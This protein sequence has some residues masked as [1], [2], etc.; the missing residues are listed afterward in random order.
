MYTAGR[1]QRL[2]DAQFSVWAS[3]KR[4]HHTLM[5]MKRAIN[6]M[7]VVV[8]VVVVVLVDK[9]RREFIRGGRTSRNSNAGFWGGCQ[10]PECYVKTMSP[11][12]GQRTSHSHAFQEWHDAEPF[13]TISQYR[14]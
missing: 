1:R 2:A 9:A 12:N 4:P 7:L 3:S 8:P 13:V 5:A 10:W 6:V 14:L 11:K